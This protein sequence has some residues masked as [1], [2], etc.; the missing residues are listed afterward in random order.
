MI[1]THAAVAY[2]LARDARAAGCALD[3]DAASLGAL[4]AR[5]TRALLVDAQ[6]SPFHAARMRNAGLSRPDTLR[7]VDLPL[8]LQSLPPLTK[9]ELREAG[10][11]ALRDGRISA[12]WLS[13]RSSGSSGEPFRVYYDARAWAMIKYLVKMRARRAAGMRL[14]DR[15]AVLDAIDPSDEG[16]TLLERAGRLRR[17][18]VFR[19]PAEIAAALSAYAPAGIY[20]LPSALLEIARA[21]DAGAPRVRVRRI[22]TSGELLTGAA[23]RAIIAAFGG[24]LSDIYGTSETK[25]LAWECSAGSRHINADVVH[26]EI[27]GDDASVA[28]RGTE[29]EIVVTLLGNRAM[30][31]L[32]Y[33]T[34]D[35]GTLLDERCPCGR[36]SPLLGVVSGREADVLELA[37]GSTLS[38]YLLTMALEPI[39]GL[40]QYRVVQTERDLLRVSAIAGSGANAAALES[41]IVAALRNELPRSMRVEADIVERLERGARAK[42]RVVQPLPRSREIP[43][44]LAAATVG[45]Q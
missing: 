6:R 14:M 19:S 40:A 38:P 21:C 11:A 30:P 4:T 27:L 28:P 13:S 9:H 5:R 26:V 31:L 37:D 7:D 34:G 18:S 41:A 25:E 42:L 10:S 20:A 36:A 8:A 2:W 23:R 44:A 3:L 16:R 1:A 39:A 15:V 17:I 32:R 12:T 45:S 22:F 35:R 29:G 43:T 24:E 33:R